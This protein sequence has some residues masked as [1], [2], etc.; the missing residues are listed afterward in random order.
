MNAP[1]RALAVALLAGL[2]GVGEARAD[3][4]VE[5][6]ETWPAGAEITLGSNQTFNLRI[7][8]STDVPVR[9]W[10]QPYYEDRPVNA[11]S[12][13]S[14]VHSGDGETLG[15][16]FFLEPS[17]RVDEIRISAGDGSAS[18]TKVLARLPVRITSGSAPAAAA[19]EPAW[20]QRLE[21]ENERLARE[22]FERS[23]STPVGPGEMLFMRA[24]MLV[25]LALGLVGIAAPIRAMRRWR[26]GWRMAA[27]VPATLIGFVI[28][29]I[30]LETALDPT[31]HNLWPFEILQAG[32]ASIVV[33][34]TLAVARKLAGVRGDDTA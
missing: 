31:S 1:T 25:V 10:A 20:L 12:N 22:D 7:A 8:Y 32:V 18:G 29:R 11:G 14:R 4:R 28:A 9:I 21:A 27:A 24:F 13:P 2:Q 26:G 17:G 16:F 30:A 3:T 15:W 34:G 33:I 5:V 23:M 19:G 6:L